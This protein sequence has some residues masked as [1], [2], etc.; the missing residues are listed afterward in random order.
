MQSDHVQ[1]GSH[2]RADVA[3]KAAARGTAAANDFILRGIWY[4][5]VIL[6]G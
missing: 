3:K 6:Q 4:V 1:E 2:A 5:C